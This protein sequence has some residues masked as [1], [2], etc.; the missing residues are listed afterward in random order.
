MLAVISITFFRATQ[1]ANAK[2]LSA[3]FFL[4]VFVLGVSARKTDEPKLKTTFAAGDF[5]FVDKN[6]IAEI[7]VSPGD[8][9]IVEIAAND[10]VEDVYRVTGQRPKLVRTPSSP[11]VVIIGTLGK[12]ELIGKLKIDTSKIACGRESFLIATVA[13]PFPEVESALVI[14]GSDRRGTALGGYHLSQMIG[15]SS[16]VWWADVVPERKR[17]LVLSPCQLPVTCFWTAGN[18]IKVLR[19]R[20]ETENYEHFKKIRLV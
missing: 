10:L 11:D 18:K 1:A 3:L 5:K 2:C 16:W 19:L 15:V 12:S 7:L 17:N 9:T 6:R 8:L 14:A 20:Q 13:N 4:I